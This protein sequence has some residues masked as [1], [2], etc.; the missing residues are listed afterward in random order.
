[1]TLRQKQKASGRSMSFTFLTQLAV[2][3][4]LPSAT[5]DGAL[6]ATYRRVPIRLIL[7]G[8]LL[9]ALIYWTMPPLSASVRRQIGRWSLRIG[10]AA[11]LLVLLRVGLPWL[12]IIGAGLVGVLRLAMPILVRLLP[13][14]FL[15]R[16]NTGS[17]GMPGSGGAGPDFRRAPDMTRA[18]A[19]EVLDLRE[20][21]SRQEI[22]N[23]YKELIKKVHPD[24][25][26]S[27]YLAA[28]VN[29]ARDVLLAEDANGPPRNR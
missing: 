8:L 17:A 18:H 29:R 5:P 3:I 9:I 22:L 28:E 10:I 25:G 14:W 20:G 12:A 13:L 1:V 6:S 21:A 26:G 19:L 24:R 11:V 16:A 23:A 7:M 2:R 4:R 15:R 27:S